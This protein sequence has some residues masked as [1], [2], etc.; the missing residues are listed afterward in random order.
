MTGNTEEDRELLQSIVALLFSLACVASRASTA[1]DPVRR[2]VLWIMQPAVACARDAVMGR[3]IDRSAYTWGDCT[4]D[5]DGPQDAI[6]LAR[7]FCVLAVLHHY[8]LGRPRPGREDR[9]GVPHARAMRP[10]LILT[11]AE[12]S[13]GGGGRMRSVAGGCAKL[14]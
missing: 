9:H 8:I 1:P 13:S 2:Y 12:P 11:A 10:L 4:G 14:I 3:P 6:H 7:T 5:N